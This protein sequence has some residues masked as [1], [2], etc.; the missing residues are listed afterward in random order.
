MDFAYYFQYF[1]NATNPQVY[2]DL[3]RYVDIAFKEH[4]IEF[5]NVSTPGAAIVETSTRLNT[6][7][8][9]A[10]RYLP[11]DELPEYIGILNGFTCPDL[12]N[13]TYDGSFSSPT[14]TYYW[15]SINKC[16]TASLIEKGF[17]NTTCASDYDM[18][19]VI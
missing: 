13:I 1:N 7:I 3:D 4:Y 8:C 11:T 18:N 10:D 16:S 5:L 6:T 2:A 9:T 14:M 12:A 19:E 15:L 17:E